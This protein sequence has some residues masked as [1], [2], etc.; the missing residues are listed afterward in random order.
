MS[1]PRVPKTILDLPAY[2]RGKNRERRDAA[3]LAGQ[4]IECVAEKAA[5]GRTKCPTC[6]TINANAQRERRAA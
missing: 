1:Y 6:L 3:K 5:P 4:C 2:M